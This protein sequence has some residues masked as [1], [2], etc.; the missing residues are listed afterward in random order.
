MPS[1][2]V[3]HPQIV[4]FIIALGFVGVGLR[5]FSL[6]GRLPWTRSAAAALLIM[7]ALAG[8]AAAKSGAEAHGPL[9]R[10]PGVR[11]AVEEHEEAGENARNAFL[12]IGLL[13]LGAL[14]MTRRVAIQRGLHAASAVAGLVGAF[15]LFEAGEHGGALVYSYAGGP[16]MRSGDSTDIRRL[17]VSGLYNQADKDRQA[18]R[19][20]DAARLTDELVRRMP[21]DQMTAF[22]AI[23]SKL[24]DRKDAQGALLDLAT[25]S[26][27]ADDPRLVIRK[28]LLTVEALEV[29]GQRDSAKV[30][31]DALAK[32][33]P[34]SRMV[35]EALKKMP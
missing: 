27:P 13:E 15:F 28:G 25:I 11:A 4:H 20:D 33:F 26:A 35:G 16:G 14:A 17:L 6:T 21:G 3:F 22:L 32:Q 18:G 12:V 2:A 24:K 31:L 9:E 19:G 1:I 5:I 8:V 30:I 7:A 23:E 34:E 10:I 29:L